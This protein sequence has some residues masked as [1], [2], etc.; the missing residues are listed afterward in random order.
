MFDIT[1]Y[2]LSKQFTT[3]VVNRQAGQEIDLARYDGRLDAEALAAMKESAQSIV[4]L[5]GKIYRLTFI[6]DSEYKYINTITEGT[7]TVISMTELDIDK[8]TGEFS[9]K[10][11][12]VDQTPVGSLRAEFEN[13]RDDEVRHITAEERDFWNNKVTAIAEQDGP[14]YKLHL[15]KTKEI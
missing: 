10:P 4:N 5:D 1:A 12:I 15:I 2:I 3:A 8:E 7:S 11:L 13:H 9:T 6:T 14:D